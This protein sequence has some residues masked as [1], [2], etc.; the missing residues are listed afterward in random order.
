[1]STN[2]VDAGHLRAFL[3]RIER[4]EEEK[5]AIADDIKEVYAEAKGTGYDVKIMRKIVSIRRMDAEKR[6]EEEEI[7]EIYLAALG[8]A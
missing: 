1:M 3:E 2:S 8:E 6:R 5:R 7:L 4:L